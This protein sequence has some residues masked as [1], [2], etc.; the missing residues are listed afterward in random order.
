[1]KHIK[2]RKNTLPS[3]IGA[4]KDPLANFLRVWQKK[5]AQEFRPFSSQ[6]NELR[7]TTNSPSGKMFDKPATNYKDH[8]SVKNN[9]A[10]LKQEIAKEK[11]QIVDSL[12]KLEQGLEEALAETRANVP[13]PVSRNNFDERL[14]FQV[15]APSPGPSNIQLPR[16]KTYN[17]HDE[18]YNPT[19]NLPTN[20]VR[21]RSQL[22]SSRTNTP[23]AWH[24]PEVAVNW[25]AN[26]FTS[27]P[28]VP[29]G[30]PY[31]S[32]VQNYQPKLDDEFQRLVPNPVSNELTSNVNQQAQSLRF[33]EV[34]P[35]PV[36]TSLNL[37]YNTVDNRQRNG[38][39]IGNGGVSMT[40]QP[41]YSN[42]FNSPNSPNYVNQYLIN[43][44]DMLQSYVG[45]PPL[46]PP[47][48]HAYPQ[49]SH[50]HAA[51]LPPLNH[52]E[53]PPLNHNNLLAAPETSRYTGSDANALSSQGKVHYINL[54]L[55]RK[56]K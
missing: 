47:L 37:M 50:Q 5:P 13:K 41:P 28:Y 35:N 21:P 17:P 46:T 4:A 27:G 25:M 19:L 3:T 18:R 2:L 9:K 6:L 54:R 30:Q 55:Q 14:R 24:P 45:K 34:K 7:H 32:N 39:E 20:D 10:S 51:L 33:N 22:L 53:L 15:Q 38:N 31:L 56:I 49:M 11:E 52:Q 16:D 48:E 29:Q 26:R 44:G 1:M 40:S 42:D 12:G 8:A 36:N 23:H 43:P